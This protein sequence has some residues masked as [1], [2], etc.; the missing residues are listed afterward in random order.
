[1]PNEKLSE[2]NE[3]DAEEL[4]HYPQDEE[5][6]ERRSRLLPGRWTRRV[7]KSSARAQARRRVAEKTSEDHAYLMLGAV[8]FWAVGATSLQNGIILCAVLIILML[9]CSALHLILRRKLNLAEWV[10][11]PLTVL[12]AAMLAAACCV[13]LVLYWPGAFDS[14]GIY[15]FL[16]VAAPV[17]L[18][19]DS[20]TAVDNMREFWGRTLRFLRDFCIIILVSG[21]LRELLRHNTLLGLPAFCWRCCGPWR[22]RCAGLST[23]GDRRRPW[24]R[25]LRHESGAEPF[26]PAADGG[27]GGKSFLYPL[28]YGGNGGCP[29]E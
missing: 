13:A 5:Q 7:Q 2:I 17:L 20:Y 11:L 27:P 23:A 25:R 18:Q 28:L 8:P 26:G 16:L 3:H 14:L 22:P 4:I 1:M 12:V 21:A 10:A 15:L 9:P 24:G 29:A 19:A 6:K